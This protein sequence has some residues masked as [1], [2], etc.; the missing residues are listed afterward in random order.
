MEAL[1][2]QI[3]AKR[4]AKEQEFSGQ[5]F[6]K[7]GEIEEA[8]L[9]QKQLE[10][11]QESAQKALKKVLTHQSSKSSSQ[12]VAESPRVQQD[13]ELERQLKT[14]SREEIIRR[15]RLLKQPATLFGEEDIDRL[16]RLLKAEEEFDI[17]DEH[18]GG[19]QGNI[20]LELEREKKEADAKRRAHE[21]EQKK[22]SKEEEEQENMMET[23]KKAAERLQEKQKEAT[24]TPDERVLKAIQNW[25]R[26]WEDDLQQR[27]EEVKR[28]MVGSQASNVYQQTKKF[29]GPMYK[30]MKRGDMHPE[31]RLGIHMMVQVCHLSHCDLAALTLHHLSLRLRLMHP[32]PLWLFHQYG[33]II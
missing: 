19:Q 23:F 2:A 4:K 21:E 5:K 10:E 18:V 27:P 9:R 13:K 30:A 33:P 29:F 22:K 17:G 15:L 3:E 20:I 1:K 8:R 32:L 26:E 14:H 28:S 11:E 25:L 24:L 6:K 31:V 16:K 7:R 12:E